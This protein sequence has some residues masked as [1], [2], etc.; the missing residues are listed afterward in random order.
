MVWFGGIVQGRVFHPFTFRDS[1]GRWK[2][3]KCSVA[4]RVV[5]SAF[6]SVADQD[7]GPIARLYSSVLVTSVPGGWKSVVELMMKVILRFLII[8]VLGR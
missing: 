5:D 7:P 4:V 8:K 2:V 1:L 3:G 6:L